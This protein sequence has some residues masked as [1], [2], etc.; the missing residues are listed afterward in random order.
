MT[1]TEARKAGRD[2]K[3]GHYDMADSGKATEVGETTGFIKVV[4]DAH[5]RPH[6]GRERPVL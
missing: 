4:I 3:I 1:E 5:Y 6:F 2:I